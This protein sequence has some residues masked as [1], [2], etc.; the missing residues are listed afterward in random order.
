[1]ELSKDCWLSYVVLPFVIYLSDPQVGKSFLK[2][3]TEAAR[4]KT[5]H[6]DIY[7]QFSA[8]F[9]PTIV[10]KWLIMVER[11]EA[12]PSMPNPYQEPKAGMC[13]SL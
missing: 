1:M 10:K 6:A 2:K 11:W 7:K 8:T 3:F 12:D 4:M 9:T 13:D 5:K